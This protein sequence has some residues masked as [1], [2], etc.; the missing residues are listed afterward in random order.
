M[1]MVAGPAVTYRDT[2]IHRALL[3]AAGSIVLEYAAY[4][5]PKPAAHSSR[6][7]AVTKG[8]CPNG[9]PTK[10]ET[11]NGSK[12]PA[13]RQA[14]DSPLYKVTPR[15]PPLPESLARKG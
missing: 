2:R 5:S 7:P 3:A 6:L 15:G 9:I 14:A 13:Q 8:C 4:P 12:K 11:K 10:W 1:M